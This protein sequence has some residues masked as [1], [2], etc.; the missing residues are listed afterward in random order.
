MIKIDL[1]DNEERLLLNSIVN[2]SKVTSVERKT[3]VD[4]LAFSR[5][6]ADD[7]DDMIM[8]LIDGTLSKVTALS[9][10]EWNSIRLLFPLPVLNSAEDDVSE[11]ELDERLSDVV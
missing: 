6:I 4:G 2:G 11:E 1:F 10:D 7:T 9:N 8:G 3:I 5:S